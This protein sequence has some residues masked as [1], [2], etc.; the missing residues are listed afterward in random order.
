MSTNSMYFDILQAVKQRV[1]EVSGDIVPT[2]RKRPILLVTDS[3]PSIIITTCQG[4]PARLV[5]S[6]VTTP[7]YRAPKRWS[8]SKLSSA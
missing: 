3:I 2:I 1:R 7:I 6:S 8:G 4:E 5:S